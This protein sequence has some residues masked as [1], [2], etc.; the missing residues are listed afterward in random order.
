[1]VCNRVR[2]IRMLEE[3]AIMPLGATS[4]DDVLQIALVRHV[5]HVFITLN[6]GRMYL[7]VDGA[8][9][10]H[11][12]CRYI[13]PATDEHRRALRRKRRRLSCALL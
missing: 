13:E 1:M 11:H 10:N 6:D 8:D 5:G 12:S 4:A 3:V 2:D 7:R 9:V